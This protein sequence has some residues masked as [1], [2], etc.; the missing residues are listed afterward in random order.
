MYTFGDF[1]SRSNGPWSISYQT[2]IVNRRHA[3]HVRKVH[4]H[5]EITKNTVRIPFEDDAY[6]IHCTHPDF[7]KFVVSHI[8]YAKIEAMEAKDPIAR[9][10]EALAKAHV[11]D[12]QFQMDGEIGAR[13]HI[14]WKMY[15]YMI[16]LACLDSATGRD[17]RSEYKALLK[18]YADRLT[19]R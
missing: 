1:V 8:Q 14:A 5:W 10:R 9:A 2:R 3:K 15:H 18:S 12:L 4:V 13:Q 11:H 6:F 7:D 17:V 16:A 19:L